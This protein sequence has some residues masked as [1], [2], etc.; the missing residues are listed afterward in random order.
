MNIEEKAKKY[1]KTK[2]AQND[3]HYLAFKNGYKQCISDITEF[4]RVNPKSTASQITEYL[5]SL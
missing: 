2:F 3:A 4:I 1:A 5:N